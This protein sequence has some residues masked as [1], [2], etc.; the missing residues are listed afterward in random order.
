MFNLALKRFTEA[1]ALFYTGDIT[2]I[3]NRNTALKMQLK[4]AYSRLTFH[5]KNYNLPDCVIS[6]TVSY[7]HLTLPTKLEV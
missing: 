3:T 5:L 2:G 7:T 1:D 6:S 4:P